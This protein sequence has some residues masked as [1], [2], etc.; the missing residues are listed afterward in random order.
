MSKKCWFDPPQNTDCC[1]QCS[2]RFEVENVKTKDSE[3]YVCAVLFFYDGMRKVC[4]GDFE[5]G[6][7]EVCFPKGIGG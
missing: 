6:L 5:H 7:C 2:Y 1:C 3:G 4:S